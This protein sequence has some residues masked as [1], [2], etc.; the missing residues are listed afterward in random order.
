MILL[1]YLSYNERQLKRFSQY[2]D[3]FRQILKNPNIPGDFV[4]MAEEDPK[5]SR[6]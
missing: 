4:E 5:M 1:I 6:L 2:F 3:N